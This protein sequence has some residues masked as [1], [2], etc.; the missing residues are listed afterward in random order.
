MTL[1]AIEDLLAQ[2]ACVRDVTSAA[3]SDLCTARKI[4]LRRRLSRGRR[5]LYHRYLKHCFEDRVLTPDEIDDLC[6]LRDLLHLDAADLI[7]VQNAVAVEVYG[8]AVEEVLADFRLD[9]DE[10]AFLRA[11][12]KSLD[13]PEARAARIYEERAGR[14]RDRA[15]S[16]ATARDLLFLEHRAPAGEFTGRSSSSLERAIDDALTKASLVVPNLHW[17]EVTHIAGYAEEGQASGWHISLKAGIR[18]DD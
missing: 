9:D 1:E 11:L 15:L 8:E 13:L 14:A 16:E 7:A 10:A 6:H 18:S 3:V 5:Q 2:A 12:T 4:D 17:F